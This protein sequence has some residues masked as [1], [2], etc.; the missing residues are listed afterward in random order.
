M[1]R[2]AV[3]CVT[4]SGNDDIYLQHATLL[5]QSLAKKNI[6][7]VYSGADVGLMGAVANGALVKEE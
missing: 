2:V 3:F 6:E 7:L 1:K 5:G 4:S